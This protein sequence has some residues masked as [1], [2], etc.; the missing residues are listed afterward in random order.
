MSDPSTFLLAL[1]HGVKVS[2]EAIWSRWLLSS[3][4]GRFT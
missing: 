2:D 1:Y 4:Y 3:G